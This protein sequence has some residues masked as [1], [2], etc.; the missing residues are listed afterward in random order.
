MKTKE[1]MKNEIFTLESR[2]LNEGKKVLLL[3]VSI[4]T[5]TRLT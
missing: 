4:E 2:E 5:L 1:S 3:A